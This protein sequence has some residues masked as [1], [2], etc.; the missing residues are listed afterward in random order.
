MRVAHLLGAEP[1]ALAASPHLGH[2]C[3]PTPSLERPTAPTARLVPARA[4]R[5]PKQLAV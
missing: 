1:A 5:K 4:L 2:R 3:L